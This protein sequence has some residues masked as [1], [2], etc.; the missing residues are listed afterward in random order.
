M[1]KRIERVTK[2]VREILDDLLAGHQ[3]A[4]LRGAG[5]GLKYLER[6]LSEQ[7]SLP[8]AVKGA[9]FSLLAEERA[10]A[11]D[12]EGTAEAVQAFLRHLPSLEEDLG[13]GYRR[14]LE[15]STALERGVQAL[16]ELADFHGALE[17]CDRAIALDLGAHWEAKRDSLAWAR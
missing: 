10:L 11:Q 16:T 14:F 1:A 4:R 15:G 8:N 9:A 13:H 7:G 17:L 12:W 2:S 5:Q 3:E 6:T